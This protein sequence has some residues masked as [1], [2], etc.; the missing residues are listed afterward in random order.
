[1]AFG[2]AP[3]SLHSKQQALKQQFGRNTTTPFE[4]FEASAVMKTWLHAAAE[5]PRDMVTPWVPFSMVYDTF[6]KAPDFVNT[7]ARDIIY[8]GAQSAAW[9]VHRDRKL[10]ELT[11]KM[12]D[13]CKNWEAVAQGCFDNSTDKAYY[14]DVL[15]SMNGSLVALRPMGHRHIATRFNI[16]HF[17]DDSPFGDTRCRAMRVM[18]LDQTM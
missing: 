13:H 7:D 11:Q 8:C 9:R 16:A 5:N 15:A 18:V 14:H 3:H 12:Y 10:F 6:R 1:L 17:Q 4:S 2:D